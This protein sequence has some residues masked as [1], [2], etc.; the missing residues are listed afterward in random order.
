MQSTS[1]H[2]AIDWTD[3]VERCCDEELAREIVQAFFADKPADMDT[4]AE[5]VANGDAAKI[6]SLA[7]SLKGSA[8]AIS[9][10]PL[11]YVAQDLEV[12]A[13]R[14]DM[15]SARDIF[16]DVLAEFNRLKTLVYGND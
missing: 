8:A 1:Q 6:M 15:E 3:L 16:E 4:L 5:A 9:A 14:K 11:S 13:A 7:H 2:R 10:K 12:A